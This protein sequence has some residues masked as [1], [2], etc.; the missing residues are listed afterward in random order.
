[1]GKAVAL[2]GDVVAIPGQVPYPPAQSGAW[3]PT[4]V[5]MKTHSKLKVGGKAVIYEAECKF[6][7]TGVDS[8]SGAPVAV[9]GNETVK[10]S[11]KST[12]L[13]KKVLVQG[14]A[15]QG[16]YGNQLKVVATGKLATS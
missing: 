7:F 9:S 14:D 8:S 4:P 6:I 10:L 12:K 13:Q 16:S 5:Q 1:M 2:Q 3:V 15:M 11:A